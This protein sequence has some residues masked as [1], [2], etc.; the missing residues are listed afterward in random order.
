MS[1]MIAAGRCARSSGLDGEGGVGESEGQGYGRVLLVDDEPAV[2]EV[3]RQILEHFGYTVLTAQ[4]GKEALALFERQA[5][6]FR[7]VIL[8]LTMPDMGGVEVCKRLRE[9]RP[10]IPI[11]LSSGYTVSSLPAELVGQPRT[12]FL[13]KPYQASA[14]IG[15]V[16]AL[17]GAE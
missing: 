6:E 13:Q 5:E 11:L 17:I 9:H 7:I 14:L 1:A 2:L 8:D 10:L 3:T 15:K 16:Q 12:G 4:G